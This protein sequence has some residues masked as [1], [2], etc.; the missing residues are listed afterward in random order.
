VI[1]AAVA[2]LQQSSVQADRQMQLVLDY[3]AE[4]RYRLA[5]LVRY[6]AVDAVSMVAHGEAQLAVAAFCARSGGL[7]V[8]EADI[9]A[10]GGRVEYVRE[11]ARRLRRDADELA[12]R[13][14]AKGIDMA[15]VAE[16]LELPEYQVRTMVADRTRRPR[17]IGG[18]S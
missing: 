1:E 12:V 8:V 17:R 14:L 4:H 6:G 11:P 7:A 5:G 18:M 3:L 9:I 15:L 10:A 2:V 13:M 16:L